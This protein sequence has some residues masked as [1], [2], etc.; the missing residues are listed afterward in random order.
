MHVLRSCKGIFVPAVIVQA[1]RDLQQCAELYLSL[2]V[3]GWVGSR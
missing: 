3:R 2:I 1:N